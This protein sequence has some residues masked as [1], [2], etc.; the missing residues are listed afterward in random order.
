[1]SPITAEIMML[2]AP[3]PIQ[4]YFQANANLDLSGMLAPFSLD[5]VVRDERRTHR[6]RDEIRVWIEQATIDNKAIAVP[7]AIQSDGDAH[8]VRAQVSGAF[9]GSPVT[10]SFRF[11]LDEDRIAELEIG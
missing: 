2:S 5:A 10:L 11:R 4:A 9:A 1:M 8:Q 3:T 6:G 7:Q